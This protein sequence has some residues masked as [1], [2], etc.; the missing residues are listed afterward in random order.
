M[1]TRWDMPLFFSEGEESGLAT[2]SSL[3]S[4]PDLDEPAD[5]LRVGNTRRMSFLSQLPFIHEAVNALSTVAE[6]V[7]F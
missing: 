1:R 5:I 6:L 2:I 4:P 7:D 3:L